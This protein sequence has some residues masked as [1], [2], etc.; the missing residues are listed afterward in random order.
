[1]KD[2]DGKMAFSVVLISVAII[3][4]LYAAVGH[5]G[6]SGYLA[7]MVLLGYGVAFIKPTALLLNMVVSATSFLHFYR[8]GFFRK[9]LFFPFII[10]SVPMAYLGAKWPVSDFLFKFLLA[11]CL[12]L[13][14]ARLLFF[15][16]ADFSSEKKKMPFGAALVIGAVIGLISGMIGIGG[17]V[18]LSPVLLLF[19]WADLKESAA[20]AAL[21]I[22]VNSVS[23]MAGLYTSDTSFSPNMLVMVAAAV[24]GGLAG[25]YTGVRGNTLVL[26]YILSAVMVI[27]V[28]KLLL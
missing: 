21:F 15:R 26:K 7:L 11:F 17:G 16:E 22:L 3:A 2:I 12:L 19:H 10:F 24:V 18:L 25:G 23:G 27:A 4:F 9:E 14:V 5:G 1:M 20:V 13:S 6:A 28:V 8:S